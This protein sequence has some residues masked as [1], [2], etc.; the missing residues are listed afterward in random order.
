MA[1]EFHPLKS[2]GRHQPIN[3]Y[4]LEISADQVQIAAETP[5][6]NFRYLPVY[7]VSA[8]EAAG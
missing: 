4:G 3:F 5:L 1:G 7:S 6:E 2:L 8:L